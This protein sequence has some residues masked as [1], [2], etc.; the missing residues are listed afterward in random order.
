MTRISSKV[1]AVNHL[2][3]SAVRP[4]HEEQTMNADRQSGPDPLTSDEELMRQIIARQQSALAPLYSRYAP[5]IFHM[6]AQTLG[7]ASAEDIVQEVFITLWRRAETFDPKRG[8]VRPWLLQIAHYQILNELRR[9]SRRPQL[10]PDSDDKLL[11]NISAAD[12]E[13]FD[14]AWL[15]YRREA[16]Q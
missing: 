3:A 5:L 7:T 13:P 9:R 12:A 1:N 16:L 6:A 11:E 15:A 14:E 4:P 10:D 2:A 8:S